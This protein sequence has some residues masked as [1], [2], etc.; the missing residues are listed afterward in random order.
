MQT[1][2]FAATLAAAAVFGLAGTSH[3]D[4]DL[5]EMQAIAQQFG[6]ISLDEAKAKAL[7]AKPGVITDAEL[8]DR[9]FSKGWDYEFE[10]VDADA[11]EWELKIDAKT[12]ETRKVKRDWF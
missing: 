12:G 8:D 1:K 7:A 9:D 11:R 2:H 10:I 4:D 5:Q 3:A 6:L